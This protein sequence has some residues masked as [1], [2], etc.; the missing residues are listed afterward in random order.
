ML[1]KPDLWG[2]GWGAGDGDGGSGRRWD[3]ESQGQEAGETGLGRRV[4]LPVSP[5]T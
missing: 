1:L 2:G 3:A 4:T 5:V